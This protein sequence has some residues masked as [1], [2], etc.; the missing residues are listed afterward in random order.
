MLSAHHVQVEALKSLWV[1]ACAE[2]KKRQ[3]PNVLAEVRVGHVVCSLCGKK[4]LNTQKLCSHIRSKHLEESKYKCQDCGKSVGDAWAL[5]VISSNTLGQE[6]CTSVQSVP[7]AT[8]QVVTSNNTWQTTLASD[9]FAGSV[10]RDLPKRGL[11]K[12][13]LWFVQ[14]IP[15]QQQKSPLSVRCVGRSTVTRKTS[16]DIRET[17][18]KWNYGFRAMTVKFGP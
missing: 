13:T 15:L 16:K 3:A 7:R 10:A 11:R 2:Y 14:R 6:S 9:I 1:D 4:C 8:P 5:N 12:A 18:I 17:S